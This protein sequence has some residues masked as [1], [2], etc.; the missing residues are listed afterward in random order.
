VSYNFS[1]AAI[2][3]FGTSLPTLINNYP[4]P[5]NAVTGYAPT[6]PTGLTVTGTTI[7]SASLSWVAPTVTSTASAAYEYN[8]LYQITGSPASNWVDYGVFTSTTL[9]VSGLSPFITYTFNVIAVNDF[10]SS[11]AASTS[12]TLPASVTSVTAPSTPTALTSTATTYNTASL[13][14]TASTGSVQYSISYQV[15]G[16][17]ATVWNEFGVTANTSLT[18]TG[19]SPMVTYNFE[20]IGINNGGTSSGCTLSNIKLPAQVTGTAPSAPTNFTCT[21]TTSS[22]ASLSWDSMTGAYEYNILYQISGATTWADFTVTTSTT[23]TVT[24]LA[25]NITYNFQVFAVNNY[26]SSAASTISATQLPIAST[27]ATGTTPSTPTTLT[28]NSTTVNSATLTWT[29]SSTAVQ[30]NVLYQISGASSWVDYAI[31]NAPTVT[32]IVSG[33]VANVTYIFQVIAI[34]NYGASTA[35]GST[36]TQLPIPSNA[37]T[38]TAPGTPTALTSSSVT[39]N[40]LTLGWT[41]P[42]TGT[43]TLEYNVLYQVSGATSWVDY[44]ITTSTSTSISGLVPNATYNFNVIALNN[45]GASAAGSLTNV[46]L[47]IPSNA[48]TGNA[49]GSVTSLTQ[50]NIA[51]TS[52]TLTWTAPSGGTAALEYNVLY[53]LNGASTWVDFVITTS[54]STSVTGLNAYAV[55]NFQVIALNNYGASSPTPL[56]SIQLSIPTNAATGTAPGAPTGLATSSA[57]SSGITLTWGAVTGAIQYNV[58]Y[59]LSGAS[60]WVDTTIISAPTVTATLTGLNAYADYNFGV[61]AMNNYGQSAIS[62]IMNYQM[63]PVTA[64]G[65]VPSAV[66]GLTVGTVTT[67]SAPLTWTAATGAIEYNVLYQVNGA[68]TWVDFSVVTATNATVTGLSPYVTYKFEVLAINNYGASSAT[69]VSGQ[70]LA[71]SNTGTSPSTP[72]G[73]ATSSTTSTGTTLTWTAAAN[74]I[75]YQVQYQVNG[76]STWLESTVTSSTTYAI[77]GLSP[78]VPYVFEVIAINN[79]GSSSPVTVNL[80][81]PAGTT[82]TAPGAPTAVTATGGAVA[83][84]TINLSW[85]APGTGSA[86]VTYSVLYQVSGASSWYNYTVTSSTTA[87]VTGLVASANYNFQVIAVNNYGSSPAGTA[88]CQAPSSVATGTAP[89]TPTNL[90]ATANSTSITLSWS[91]VTGAVEYNIL[92]QV[93]GATTW[94]EAGATSSTTFNVAG[95]VYPATYNFQLF[96][97]NNFGES[98]A[99][100]LSWGTGPLA[101]SG[102]TGSSPTTTSIA[103]N[104]SSGT[105]AASYN[106]VYQIG[107]GTATTLTGYTNTNTT[108]TG[109][110]A[111]TVYNFSVYSV[112]S[113]GTSSNAATVTFGTDP[114]APTALGASSFSTTGMT[115]SWTGTSTATSYN[116]TYQPNNGTWSTI[117]GVTG[118]STNLSGLTPGTLYNFYVVGVNGYGTG[119]ASSTYNT[120]TLCA[121]P[122]GLA[123]SGST[124]TSIVM[125]W[126]ATTGASTYTLS[127]QPSGGSWTSIPSISG[128]TKTVSSLTAGIVYNF[129]VVAVNTYGSSG[130]SSTVTYGTISSS[131]TGLTGSNATTTS[132]DLNWTASTGA[133]SYTVTY[134]IGSGTMTTLS[135]LTGTSK[136]VGSLTAG[137]VYNFYIV[138]VNSYGTSSTG[139]AYVY[140]T[141][142]GAPS[143]LT[144]SS[145]S[146]TGLTIAWNASTGATSYNVSYQYS[147]QGSWSTVNGVSGTSTSLSGL[148]PGTLYNIYVNAVDSYGT[149]PASSTYNTGTLC[150]APTGLTASSAT[151]ASINVSWT[152]TTGVVTY[153]LNYQP[154]GG[155]WSQLTSLTGTSTTV[156]GLSGGTSYNMYL[157]AV[158]NYGSSG[159]GNTITTGTTPSA[160]TGVTGGTATISTVPVSWTAATGATSYIVKYT[161]NSTPYSLAS[162]SSTSGTITGL[163]AGSSITIYVTASNSYGTSPNSGTITYGT[164]SDTVTSLAASSATINSVNLS[165]TGSTG[166]TSYNVLYQPSGG[167]WSAPTNVTSTSK[168]VTGLTAGTVYAFQVQSLNSY[169]T[170]PNVA[171]VN[172]GTL[173]AAPTGLNSTGTTNNSITVG[174]TATTGVSTYTLNY[175]VSGGSWSQLTNLTG[176]SKTVSSLSPGT[177]YNLYLNAINSYGTSGNSGTISS[178]TV[179]DAPT[180]VSANNATAN[181]FIVSW[182]GVTNAS[183]YTVYYQPSGGSWSSNSTASTSYTISSLTAGTVY[184][185]YVVASNTAATS[186]QSSTVTYGT[187]SSTPGGF[188]VGSST[189]TTATLNWNS[190]TGASSYTITGGPST[191]TGLTGTSYSFSGLTAGTSY[192]FNIS[193]VNSYG[194]SSGASTSLLTVP[195]APSGLTVNGTATSSSIPLTWNSATSATSYTINY[196]PNDASGGNNV[197]GIS[198]TST[199]ISNLVSSTTYTFTVTAVNATGSGPTSSGY[200][201]ATPT[202][203]QP[204]TMAFSAATTSGFTVTLTVTGASTYAIRVSTDNATWTYF[205]SS[206]VS[207]WSSSNVIAATSL[208]SQTSYYVQAAAATSGGTASAWSTSSTCSTNGSPP[209]GVTYLQYDGGGG[210]SWVNPDNTTGNILQESSNSGSTWTTIFTINNGTDQYKYIGTGLAPTASRWW[211]CFATNQWGTSSQYAVVA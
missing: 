192:T 96:S 191:Q 97:I 188:S 38:G 69:I 11:T 107:S 29:A 42:T 157:V 117:N 199:T 49:P 120:G 14:W 13:S 31:V 36:S 196:T 119:P 183:N 132:L 53:Q 17:T 6:A 176:T 144:A 158:N 88:S 10:G 51:P 156:N 18:V 202:S 161:Y 168:S 23:T 48:A 85:T 57:T 61:I 138:S 25:P 105:G 34:N 136:T 70:T 129:Y 76:A 204:P 118:T 147:G 178:T 45:Y 103:L 43:A 167:S 73:L 205:P 112:N 37:A 162:T 35:V 171:N 98:S 166:A 198:S 46:Q 185:A 173:C 122:T 56:S 78:L 123:G 72:T 60:T 182:N 200:S 91:A 177:S 180:G 207:S 75:Q 81:M 30:Y 79:Y 110:A 52:L 58:L 101:P 131:P 62:E 93:S 95:L 155:S 104:W 100:T 63:P 145:F 15:T 113:Y 130:Q 16:T 82:G 208:S 71:T 84:N 102:A 67:T 32:K 27:S 154:S 33:L 50:S 3:N 80:T 172:Y 106:V 28:V 133:T 193:A 65:S 90:T 21:A 186:A 19:L 108:V 77:T 74:D 187:V 174:W 201:Y 128:T 89:A 141:D 114:A 194:T 197:S 99:A 210:L 137:T 142:S 149:S 8:V 68:S 116:V 2:N 5:T 153:T 160:P 83:S 92:Y 148:S 152:A 86:V 4:M 175:Q 109:L 125:N 146:T 7:S 20:V 163:A 151:N 55:Y 44:T 140:G 87:S 22:S 134:Q 169:G 209:G 139:T 179:L 143:G 150:A 54:T 165:W 39:T 121:A 126:T 41:A 26:G 159:N 24:G 115:V 189:S 12:A 64:V 181:S 195:P 164:L 111:D 203:I 135:G 184:S 47:L 206:T 211:R 94:A 59:Q 1:V 124:T 40:S 66:T 190:V 9:L 170:G 127:Y